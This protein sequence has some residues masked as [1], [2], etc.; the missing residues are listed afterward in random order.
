MPP[1]CRSAELALRHDRASGSHQ[2]QPPDRTDGRTTK[3]FGNLTPRRSGFPTRAPAGA[4]A[5]TPGGPPWRRQTASRPQHRVDRGGAGHPRRG[6]VALASVGRPRRAAARPTRAARVAR[7]AAARVAAGRR[8]GQHAA[9]GARGDRHARRNAGRADR[10]RHG[11]AA[12]H[13]HRAAAVERH[14]AGR[15]FQG[16][17]DG[18]EGRRARPDR[19][20][21]LSDLAAKTRKARWRATR[22]CCKPPAST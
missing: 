6:A 15:V 13:R 11:H 14:V 5:G 17:P 1:A 22:R 8:H 2:S 19:P 3:A 21:S 12:C 7:A 18:Q 9:A 10:A 20:A 4:P 16:R